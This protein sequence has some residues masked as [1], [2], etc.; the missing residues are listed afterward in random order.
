VA[1]LRLL[2]VQK[3]VKTEQKMSIKTRRKHS[4][5]FKAKVAMAALARDKTLPQLAQEFDAYPN[6]ITECP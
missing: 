2:N 3:D 4:P 5:A 1:Q 6:P